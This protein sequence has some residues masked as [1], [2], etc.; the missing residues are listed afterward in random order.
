MALY[1]MVHNGVVFGT[2]ADPKAWPADLYDVR[3][4]SAV[5]GIEPG[6]TANAD[7]TYT[8]PPAP[9][10]SAA[11][12]TTHADVHLAAALSSGITGDV[13][14][15]G[16]PLVIT[17]DTTA[18]G[19]ANILGLLAAYSNGVKQSTDTT[20][21][22][23]SSGVVQLTQA[24]LLV[25]ARAVMAHTDAAYAAWHAAVAGITAS[26]PTVTTY[27]QVEAAFASLAA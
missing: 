16:S 11:Q 7:G 5:A 12:L 27:A 1:A 24:Q 2:S 14:S 4:V 17:A 15:A 19:K 26:P 8:A 13:G 3:E 6:W 18:D 20:A 21:W 9:V 10:Y 23:Q 22:Y 25:I